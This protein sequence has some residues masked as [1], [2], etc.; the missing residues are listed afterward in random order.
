[1]P[2]P[3]TTK[4][5]SEAVAILAELE[6]LGTASYKK[7]MLNHGVREPLFG[8]KISELQKI[9][10]RLKKRYELALELYGTRNYD[11]MYLAGMIADEKRLTKDD[12]QRWLDTATHDPIAS[13][14]VSSVAAEGDH[15]WML[16]MEWIMSKDE[17]TASTGWA[18][19]SALISIKPDSALD[20]PKL[21]QM[22]LCVG[23]T[24]HEAPNDVRYAM[25]G[26]VIALGSFVA[27]LTDEAL[28][29]AECIGQVSIDMGK[30]ECRVPFAP[31]CIRKVQTMGRIGR[32]RKAARC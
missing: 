8:V 19:L 32:K 13:Y 30:T 18:T 21:N 25:N 15:G 29:V 9:R 26:F 3:E 11:A 31:D 22:L 27:S 14:V 2:T 16:A 10:K 7:V 4:P 24:M 20:I 17:R 1:M 23:K 28:A 12:L 6:S 5:S